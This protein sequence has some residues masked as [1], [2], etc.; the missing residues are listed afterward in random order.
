[1]FASVLYVIVVIAWRVCNNSCNIDMTPYLIG[2]GS[3]TTIVNNQGPQN[4]Y[5]DLG[6]PPGPLIAYSNANN[7]RASLLLQCFAAHF[8]CE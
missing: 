2:A 6:N 4:T 3:S 8:V 5:W 1:M 7:Q